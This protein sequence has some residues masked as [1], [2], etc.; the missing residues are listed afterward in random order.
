MV[1]A[2]PRIS[3]LELPVRKTRL[4][5]TGEHLL[6]RRT[7]PCRPLGPGARDTH[8]S[9]CGP[10]A[11]ACTPT[12]CIHRDAAANACVDGGAQDGARRRTPPPR[13]SHLPFLQMGQHWS[14]SYTGSTHSVWGHAD[15][16]HSTSPLASQRHRSHGDTWNRSPRS[17]VPPPSR[18]REPRPLPPK[19]EAIRLL[20]GCG[21]NVARRFSERRRGLPAGLLGLGRARGDRARGGAGSLSPVPSPLPPLPSGRRA[22][23]SWPSHC[24]FE[25]RLWFLPM[26]SK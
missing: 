8:V 20:Q 1:V 14:G 19:P 13:A 24:V 26:L 21:K 11:H 6:L 9:L 15:T 2:A 12:P 23:S 3:P 16:V 22:V 25:E 4:H 17:G 7:A 5:S 18:S 10:D